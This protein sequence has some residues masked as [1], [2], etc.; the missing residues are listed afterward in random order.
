MGLL[1]ADASEFTARH[2]CLGRRSVI[3]SKIGNID[4]MM[5]V[6]VMVRGPTG[7]QTSDL[8][9]PMFLIK[10]DRATQTGPIFAANLP[11][12]LNPKRLKERLRL[13]HFDR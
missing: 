2:F 1:G 6:H 7:C 10:P 12:A 3:Q 8:I 11:V 13:L 9:Y 4:G 5:Q